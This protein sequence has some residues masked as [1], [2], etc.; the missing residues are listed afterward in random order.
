MT[1]AELAQL[2]QRYRA[3]QDQIR[4]LGFIAP[5]SVIERYTVCATPGCRCHADPPLRHGPYFQY[6]RKIA[7]KTLTRRLDPEQAQ[8]YRDWIANR[9]RLDELLAEMDKLSQ[10]AAELL[11]TPQ[12]AAT[13]RPAPK[14]PVSVGVDIGAE[15]CGTSD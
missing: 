6:T 1:D 13:P 9:R 10:Q 15:K 11:I 2:H 7:G 14:P 4:Q 8:S 3:L 5:G 12:Q